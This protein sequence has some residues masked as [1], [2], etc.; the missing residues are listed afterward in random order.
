MI[1][2]QLDYSLFNYRPD[3]IIMSYNIQLATSTEYIDL[4]EC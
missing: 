2:N 3:K 1:L 4:K